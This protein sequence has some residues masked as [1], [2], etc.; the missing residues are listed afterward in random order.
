[1]KYFIITFVQS[2]MWRNFGRWG[3]FLM[4]K[5]LLVVAGVVL[6]ASSAMAADLR[7]PP[8]VGPSYA[9]PPPPVPYA[10]WTGSY[11]GANIGYSWGRTEN[12]YSFLRF[13]PAKDHVDVDGVIG[14]VQWGYNWQV[15]QWL[16]GFESDIQASG[17][18]GDVRHEFA[19]GAITV[20]AAHRLPWFGTARSRIGILATPSLLLYGTGG[21]AYGQVK[22]DYTLNV[23]T[24]PVADVNFKDVKAGWTAGAGAELALGGGWSGKIEYLYLD[25][26]KNE[27]NSTLLSP[28]HANIF[29]VD[30]RFTDHIARVGVNYRFGGG[31]PVYANN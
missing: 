4:R 8:P 3:T 9:P 2:F 15:G 12:D 5:H 26:G 27:I 24:T 31:G 20:D 10:S 22:S 29:T 28:T 13:T 30:R 25:L 21:V 16:F 7:P 1:L 6:I 14:G 11:F 17:Q 19:N 18:K 23:R